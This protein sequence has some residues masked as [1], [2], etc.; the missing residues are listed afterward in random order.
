MKIVTFGFDDQ[1]TED[2]RLV[3]LFDKFG[4]EATFNLNSELFRC[5]DEFG[6]ERNVRKLTSEQAKSLYEHHEVAAHTLTHPNLTRIDDENEIIRQVETDRQNL[7]V[8]FGRKVNGFAYPGGGVN[9]DRRVVEILSRNTGVRYARTNIST[10]KFD[11]PKNLFAIDP[12]CHIFDKEIFS[13]F[14]EFTNSCPE[15]LFFV[16]GHSFEADTE[17][18]WA[19]IDELL[20]RVKSADGVCVMPHREVF[21]KNV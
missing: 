19:H 11:Y 5:T 14:D 10:H 17:E 20:R 13:L 16:W 8:L 2:I 4:F 21:L 6:C 12:T 3:G 18:K 1:R 9:C 15:G 7:E